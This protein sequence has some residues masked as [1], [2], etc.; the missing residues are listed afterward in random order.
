[1]VTDGSKEGDRDSYLELEGGHQ[2]IQIDLGKE[3]EIFALWMWH[4]L[5]ALR[6]YMDVVVWVSN[7][8][9]F[10]DG[11]ETVVYHADHDNSSGL[12]I[13]DDAPYVETN[14]GRWIDC[15]GVKARYVRLH[16]NG[17]TANEE[18]HYVEVEVWGRAPKE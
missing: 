18:N 16:S 1:M 14:R 5:R 2:W 6:A 11:T 17:N 13:G 8:Q 4:Y 9:D 12:G 7:D 15:R 10:A 3:Q